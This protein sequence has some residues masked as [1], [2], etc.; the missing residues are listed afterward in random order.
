MNIIDMLA[1]LIL[2]IVEKFAL[3]ARKAGITVFGHMKRI[4]EETSKSLLAYLTVVF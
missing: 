3:V 4:F 2:S 1:E